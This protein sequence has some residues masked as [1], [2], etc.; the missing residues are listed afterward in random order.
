M[1][2]QALEEHHYQLNTVQNDVNLISSL[3]MKPHYVTIQMKASEQ[4]V[5]SNRTIYYVVEGDSS[6]RV[7]TLKSRDTAK[8]HYYMDY[9]PVV[10]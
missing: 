1:P 5:L 4:Y 2:M 9:M 8:D 6:F 3:W 10:Y 7:I